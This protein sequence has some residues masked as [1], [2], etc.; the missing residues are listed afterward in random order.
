MNPSRIIL[1]TANLGSKYGVANSTDYN[2]T[3]S[4]LILEHALARGINTLDTA[5][6]YGIAEKL[7]GKTLG[8]TNNTKVITKIPTRET[9]TFEYVSN[10]LEESLSN[11]QQNTVYGLLFHDPDI[12]KKPEIREITKRLIGAE[13]AQNIGF[14]AYSLNAIVA[15]KEIYPEWTIF[16]V[17]E[18]VLDRRLINSAELIEMA[19]SKNSIFVRSVFLQGLLLMSPREIPS[20]FRKYEEHFLALHRLAEGMRVQVLDLCLSYVTNIPWNSGTI[21]AA[22]SIN[23]LDEILNFTDVAFDW[24]EIESLPYPVIDPRKWAELN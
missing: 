2:Q 8:L 13:K 6:E 22:A 1:G 15:A 7:I 5:Y 24:E 12:Q 18:N 23:Q 17:P 19:G 20:K 11:L 9:Y 3:T 16:Q 14:S 4:K 10:C 21:V